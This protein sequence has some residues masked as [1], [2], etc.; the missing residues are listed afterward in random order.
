MTMGGNITIV[1]NLNC[2]LLRMVRLYDGPIHYLS[3]DVEGFDFDVMLGGRSKALRVQN[4]ECCCG[5]CSL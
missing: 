3:I 5:L 2:Q 1:N 4:T